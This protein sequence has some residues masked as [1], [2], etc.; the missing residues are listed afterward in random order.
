M[1]PRTMKI[2]SLAR[3]GF[4]SAVM[5]IIGTGCSWIVDGG[6]KSV[7]IASN[8][9]GA[10]VTISDKKGEVVCVQTTPAIVMLRR[11]YGPLNPE[12]YKID[13]DLQGFYPGTV[14]V[15]SVLNGWFL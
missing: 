11:A 2:S 10:K 8:P 1:L 7:R 6:Y 14:K 5:I 12:I 3:L 4:F 9:S 13:F 15:R